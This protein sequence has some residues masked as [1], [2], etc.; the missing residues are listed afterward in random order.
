M[1]RFHILFHYIVILFIGWSI[2][3][4]IRCMGHKQDYLYRI[5]VFSDTVWYETNDV[6]ECIS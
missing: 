1:V 6:V 5:V 4:A 2:P 3:I